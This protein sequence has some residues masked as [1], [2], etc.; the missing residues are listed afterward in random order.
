MRRPELDDH[1]EIEREELA[2]L[3]R[4]EGLSELDAR[5]ARS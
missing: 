5:S 2:I 1:P 4:E 3:L